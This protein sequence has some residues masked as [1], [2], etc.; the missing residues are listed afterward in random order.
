MA[1][2]IFNHSDLDFV[3]IHL[4]KTKL[5]NLTAELQRQSGA[6]SVLILQNVFI[7]LSCI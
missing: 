6:A 5:C 1:K 3:C 7:E 4:N 2:K